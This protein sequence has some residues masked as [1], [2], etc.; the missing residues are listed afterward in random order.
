[1][2]DS[3]TAASDSS[4]VL[5]RS[6]VKEGASIEDRVVEKPSNILVQ[7]DFFAVGLYRGFLSA[8]VIYS[9]RAKKE[10]HRGT[11]RRIRSEVVTVFAK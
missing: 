9:L 10:F 1:M 6:I 11:F 8:S 7:C 4:P 5:N 2:H 3:R